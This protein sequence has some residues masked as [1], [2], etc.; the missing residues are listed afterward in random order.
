MDKNLHK[1]SLWL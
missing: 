1:T